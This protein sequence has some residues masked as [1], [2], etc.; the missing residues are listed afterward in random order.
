MEKCVTLTAWHEP[1]SQHS[2]AA[3]GESLGSAHTVRFLWLHATQVAPHECSCPRV[4]G[5]RPSHEQDD[6]AHSDT[7]IV[8]VLV[9]GMQQEP[10]QEGRGYCLESRQRRSVSPV[11]V[12]CYAGGS[13]LHTTSSISSARPLNLTDA[14]FPPGLLAVSPRFGVSGGGPTKLATSLPTGGCERG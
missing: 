9:T 3:S 11:F 13:S 10:P 12:W 2:S 4:G 1:H 6:E 14:S 5:Q 8:P 7:Q